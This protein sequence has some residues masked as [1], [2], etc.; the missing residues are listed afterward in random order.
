MLIFVLVDGS[1]GRE[2]INAPEYGSVDQYIYRVQPIDR[3]RLMLV[4][5]DLEYIL[6]R[7]THGQAVNVVG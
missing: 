1:G 5:A 2:D 7:A 4:L 3:K 6:V